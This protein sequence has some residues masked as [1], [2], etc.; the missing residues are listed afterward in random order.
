MRYQFISAKQLESGILASLVSHGTLM[1]M[2]F[3]DPGRAHRT[4]QQLVQRADAEGL[5]LCI[6]DDLR[7]GFVA[8]V[9]RAF[10]SSTHPRVGYVAQDAYAGRGWLQR[11]L[12]V[13]ALQKPGLFAFNDGKWMG[14][15]AGFGLVDREWALGNYQGALF[16]PGY[17]SHYADVE[18]TLLA[19][20]DG[21]FA[22]EPNCVLIEVDP[23]KDQKAVNPRD[24][25]RFRA[26]QQNG[27]EERVKN[28]ALLGKF[29]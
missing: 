23:D 1:V 18:L 16:Y 9:N 17:Q 2:P 4:A 13:C 28:L 5:L 19:Q 14:E 21:R 25:E 11:A 12:E 26:R 29:Q 24:R 20:N 7:E 27:F 15:L 22:Y 8:L 10:S 3:I 6:H